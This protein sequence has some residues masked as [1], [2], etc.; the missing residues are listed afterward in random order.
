[1]NAKEISES[2]ATAVERA[3]GAVVR[4]EARRRPSSGIVWAAEGLVVTAAHTVH[5]EEG[6]TVT[7]ADG[8]V[9]PA[10]LLGVD[11]GT[12]VALLKVEAELVPAARTGAARRVGELVLVLGR[13]GAGLRAGLGLVATANGPWR[14]ASGGRVDRWIEVDGSLPP[15]A[16][17]GPLVD[18]EGAV[19]GMNTAALARGGSTVPVE[20]IE[21]VVASLVAHGGVRRGW[22]GVG[23][24]PARLDEKQAAAAGQERALL[25][26]AVAGDGPAA[27]GGLQVGDVV[28][29]FGGAPVADPRELHARLD[30]SVVDTAVP[31]RVLRGGA[32]V[33]LSL[34]VGGKVAAQPH[35]CGR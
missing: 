28:L 23:V 25:V 6:V 33:E 3:A 2:L 8:R 10:K 20:T 15:G 19:I 1:M 31:V 14:T 18:A 13:A 35:G 21:R 32:V 7:L 9:L 30:E 29:T 24:Q 16:S 4:V 17:G 12:D 5:R 34:T 11:H 27:A 22:L 26:V